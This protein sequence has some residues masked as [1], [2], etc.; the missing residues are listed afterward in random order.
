MTRFRRVWLARREAR[1]AALP[2]TWGANAPW[3]TGRWLV[4]LVLLSACGR[5]LAAAPYELRFSP[6][7]M[8]VWA[9]IKGKLV[10]LV[11]GMNYSASFG[12][13]EEAFRTDGVETVEGVNGAWTIRY[14]LAGPAA[15]SARVTCRAETVGRQCL[16]LS[17]TIEYAGPQ[18]S[19]FYWSDGL[20]LRL[21]H[22]PLSA[23]GRPLVRWVRP[24][25]RYEWEVPG[26]TPYPVVERQLREINLGSV[27]LILLTSWYDPDWFYGRALG[28][29]GFL[30]L[31][32][33]QQAPQKAVGVVEV[34]AAPEGVSDED[35]LALA[36]GE[37]LSVAVGAGE[38]VPVRSPGQPL[39]LIARVA[40]VT[41]SHQKGRLRWSI[42]DYYGRRVAGGDVPLSLP[43]GRDRTA[44][45]AEGVAARRGIYFLAGEVSMAG[46]KRRLLRATVACLPPRRIRL[47]ETS[48]FGM[49]ALS[50]DPHTYPDQPD[51]EAALAMM[52]RIGVRWLRGF[53]FRIAAD[54]RPDEVQKARERLAQVNRWGISV[55]VQCGHGMPEDET[56]AEVFKRDL[57]A[58]LEHFKFL[59]RY[60]E[61]GNEVNFGARAGDYVRLMLQ[62]QHQAMRGVFPEGRV[63]NAGLGGVAADWW[64]EFVA[65]GGL[66]L[67]DALSVH[68]GH[69]PRAPEFWEGWDG[70]VLRPQMLRVFDGVAAAPA[71]AP[72]VWVTEA[73]S[74]SGPIRSLL[75]LRTA[76]DY[77]VREYCVLLALGV[78]V[79][80]W[81]QFR[82]GTWY[83][84]AP[85]P[86]DVEYNF[87][88]VYADLSP[89][90]QYVAYGVMTEQ[91]EGAECLG[92][93]DLSGEDLY[94]IRFRHRDGTFVDVLWSYRE[95]HECDLAWWPP[96]QFAGKHRT[97]AE[98]WV[99]RWKTPVEVSL[100]AS[101]AVTL[102]DLM[103]NS[104]RLEATDGRV[105]LSLTGS[106]V[107]V[108]GLGDLPVSRRVW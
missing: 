73:Y 43:A 6:E 48:P 98:P 15:S 7:R 4:S 66:R 77:L 46:G 19:F 16:R 31:S 88:I 56:A 34:L 104:R 28:T 52:A 5:I 51:P 87:G 44:K 80:E 55:H 32:L 23:R 38:G 9:V 84:A 26:D 33:P 29:V 45:L 24:T 69:F 105:R 62:P 106:P 76:A 42:Y 11:D 13:R 103:G 97:P 47:A 70:W 61:V 21:T 81:Y 25:G 41:A 89:K 78:R 22:E 68:P 8:A 102:T 39:A 20:R 85:K 92:R 37:S 53:G 54:I 57:A 2:A 100:P 18:R 60:I 101:G 108:R 30:R 74:P 91:L 35:F 58:A 83:S 14:R 40:N 67:V 36:A 12:E 72:E 1:R 59:S 49:A 75:D 3:P 79:I 86:D 99:E 64:G 93:L 17:W 63:M 71:P 107:Y 27:R 95:R 65:A 50:C 96:E 90:P 10:G 94:G 82:D